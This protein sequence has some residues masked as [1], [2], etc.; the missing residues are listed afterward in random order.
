MKAA[1]RTIQV[2]Y[3]AHLRERRGLARESVVTAAATAAGLFEEL[4]AR[5]EF[6]IERARVRVA[7]NDAVVPWETP[8]AGGDRVVFLTPFGGG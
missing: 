7:V 1:N 6:R 4:A 8:L 3:F 5:H 2:E